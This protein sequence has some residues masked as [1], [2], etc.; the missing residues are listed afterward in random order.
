MPQR[1]AWAIVRGFPLLPLE[2]FLPVSLDSIFQNSWPRGKEED[3][4]EERYAARNSV[5]KQQSP[6]TC[7]KEKWPTGS[8]VV[9]KP[10]TSWEGARGRVF[11]PDHS[12]PSRASVR[13]HHAGAG[14]WKRA[15]PRERAGGKRGMILPPRRRYLRV[16]VAPGGPGLPPIK[17][18]ARQLKARKRAKLSGR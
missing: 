15:E 14:Q 17:L 6:G 7:Q 2:S 5:R 1:I 16:R 10:D 9:F 18:S 13:G 3:D 12:D 8:R 4:E 11:P